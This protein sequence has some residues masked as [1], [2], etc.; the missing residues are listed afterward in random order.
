MVTLVFRGFSGGDDANNVTLVSFAM[1]DNQEARLIA[2]TEHQK[3][4]F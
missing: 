3:P 4:V 1:T 2:E